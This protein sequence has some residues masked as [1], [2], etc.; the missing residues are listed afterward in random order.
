MISGNFNGTD[1]GRRYYRAWRSEQQARGCVV[2]AHGYAEHGD[3]YSELAARLN[4]AGF[5]V[6]AE[7]HYGHGQSAGKRADVPEFELFVE[8][9]A[10]FIRETVRPAAPELPLFLYGH[11]MGGAIALLY[12]ITY[13]DQLKGLI[14][15]GPVVR[16][17][18]QTSRGERAAARFLRRIVPSLEFRPFEAGLLSH[19]PAVVQAYIDDPLVYSRKMKVRMGDEM[20]RAGDLISDTGLRSLTLPVLMMHG[21]QDQVVPPENSEVAYRLVASRDKRREVFEGMYH[22][23]HNE[24]ER[25]K[26]YTLVTSWLTEHS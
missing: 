14:L 23:I 10:L 20:L 26:V 22:E 4:T 18:S 8:D 5:D 25:Q 7:D 21:G 13:Q 19:D 15:S 2:I 24:P 9:L 12:A 11:S 17:G 16:P 1:G 3:R 6:W